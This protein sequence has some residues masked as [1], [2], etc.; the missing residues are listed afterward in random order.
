MYLFYKKKGMENIIFF[1]INFF[2]FKC[3]NAIYIFQL[4]NV[5]AKYFLNICTSFYFILTAKNV[6]KF[7]NFNELIS[8]CRILINNVLQ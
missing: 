8:K 6:N 1:T 7:R 4:R 5:I 2:L 3:S